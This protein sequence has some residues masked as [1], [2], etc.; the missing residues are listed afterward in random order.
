MATDFLW[1]A[2]AKKYESLYQKVLELPRHA[3]Q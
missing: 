3:G 1:Q 2:S